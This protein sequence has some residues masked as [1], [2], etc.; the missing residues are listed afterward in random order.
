MATIQLDATTP[1]AIVNPIVKS[2]HDVEGSTIPIPDPLPVLGFTVTVENAE[3][4]FGELT[5]DD[6]GAYH[7]NPGDT[8]AGPASGELVFTGT[9]EHNGTQLPAT[10]R[11]RI[12]LVPGAVAV[13]E[14]E[15][16]LEVEPL[17]KPAAVETAEATEGETTEG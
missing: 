5:Q 13:A 10:G 7:F 17:P 9:I 1:V 16:Q 15:A 14:I 2:L 11:L 6:N 8:T 4:N 3:G 12:D